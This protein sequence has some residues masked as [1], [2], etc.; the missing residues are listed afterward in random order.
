MSWI[1][2]CFL[3][4]VSR[5]TVGSALSSRSLIDLSSEQLTGCYVGSLAAR[6]ALALSLDWRTDVMLVTSSPLGTNLR[7]T[8]QLMSRIRIFFGKIYS[9][10]VLGII[11]STRMFKRNWKYESSCLSVQNIP[12]K[13]SSI[14]R[15][16][17][18]YCQCI[19]TCDS[20]VML[21]F[22]FLYIRKTE[23]DTQN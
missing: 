10:K 15:K 19:S 16:V 6:L 7:C 5:T 21:I 2:I 23:V 12:R 17:S 13:N 3:L 4:W 11:L 14:V 1:W 8:G 20:L 18:D 22:L 9:Q